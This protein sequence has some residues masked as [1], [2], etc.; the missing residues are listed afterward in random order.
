M[1]VFQEG[2]LAGLSELLGDDPS[3]CPYLETT[4]EYRMWQF[5]NSAARRDIE[6]RMSQEPLGHEFSKVL[7]DN[8]WELYSR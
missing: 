2:Y 8:L 6:L 7:H 5:A 4:A 1:N 3:H